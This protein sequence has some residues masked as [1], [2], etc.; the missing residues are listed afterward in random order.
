MKRLLVSLLCVSL[1]GGEP[2]VDPKEEAL[3]AKRR[4]YWAFQ[5][6]VRVEIPAGVHP[7]DH[8]EPAKRPPLELAKLKRRLALDLTGMPPKDV[9]GSYEAML[10]RLMASP[11]YGERWGQKWLDVVR[12]AD[13]N[14]YELDAE[15][16]HA[17]RYRDYVIRSFNANKPFQQFLREQIA[18]DELFPGDKEA[19][20]ATGFWRAG[21]RHVVGGNQDEEQ[22]RQEDLIEMTHAVSATFMGLTMNCARCHNH[23]FDPILQADYYRLQAI[24][25]ATEFREVQIA[26]GEEALAADEARKRHEAKLKPIVDEIKAI[27]KP[28][29]EQFR[30][31]KLPTL[32]QQFR[33]VLEI[34]KEKRTEEQK[35]LAKE[36]ERQLSP[37][38]DEVV[39][40]IPPELKAKRAGLRKRMHEINLDEPAPAAHAYSVFTVDEARKTHVLKVGDHKHKLQEVEAGLP[41]VLKR[42]LGDFAL[43]PRGRRAGLANWLA[44]PE[45]PLVARV[46]VNRVW[47]FRMGQGIVKTMNDF[48]TLGA[49][50]SNLKLLDWLATEFVRSGY[51]VKHIDRLILT[52][53][54]YQQQAERRRR[55]DSD[56]LRDSILAVS[57]MLNPKMGGRPVK[58]PIEPEIYD[59]IFTEA[60]PD[61][62][63][64]LPKDRSEMYRR[65]VYV[66]N[67]RTVRLPMLANFDQPD[68]MSSCPER[69]T[70]THALQGLTMLN[71][72]FMQEQ[73]KAFAGR[74]GGD[75][76]K[77]NELALGRAPSEAEKRQ[78]REF[79]KKGGTAEDYH[80]AL[81]N[82]NE[83]IYL[84]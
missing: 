70:S 24:L 6:P 2:R 28:Y 65:T 64:P 12:Y 15:R 1:L 54:A 23:K 72:E 37:T 40:L 27:E 48:G 5:V 25:A 49:R 50:P 69:A 77:A 74:T 62:L 17:W 38:W 8:L 26:D 71:S 35:R 7:I 59:I 51:N 29:R 57:G 56:Q 58:T 30:R 42:D 13:T 75:V 82:R 66:L 34:A 11:R 63:W 73:A 4:S 43:D 36:A 81:L 32:D 60:E 55:M 78:A 76:A 3:V 20:V 52:S 22:N 16:E 61:N 83:F 79:S 44:D 53:K 21:P 31:D 33:E 41:L 68:T 84:P 46:F 18:G 19:L 47:Q 9:L 80:L 39:A 14:G 10:E 45:N 67:R